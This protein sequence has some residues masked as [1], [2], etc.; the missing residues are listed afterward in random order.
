MEQEQV[1]GRMQMIEN[2]VARDGVALP[3]IDFVEV[4]DSKCA[5]KC[6]WCRK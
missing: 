1:W 3:I 2:M 4:T 6:R 5:R